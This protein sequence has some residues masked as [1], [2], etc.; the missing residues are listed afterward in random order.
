MIRLKNIFSIIVLIILIA[1]CSEYLDPNP[2][3]GTYD[4]EYVWSTPSFAE[5][6][7]I[8]AFNNIHP[9]SWRVQNNELMA[10][11]TDDAVSSSISST[12][13]NFAQGLQ[14]PYFNLSHIDTWGGDY[15]SIFNINKFLENIGSVK[16]DPDSAI[17]QQFIRKFKGDAY[18]LRG[19]F[20]WKLLKRFG[21]LSDGEMM[22]I[23]VIK[24]SLDIDESYDI[25]RSTYMETILAINEDLDSALQYVPEAYTGD[26]LVT[27]VQY[28]GAP[29]KAIVLSLKGIIAAY[30]A[31]PAYNPDNDLVRW[32]SAA[33]K[34]SQALLYIDG[35]LN[36]DALPPRNFHEPENPDVIWRAPYDASNYS[37][38]I[39]NYPP[40]LRGDGRT[41]PSQNLV[42][43]FPDSLGYPITDESTVYNSES[44]YEN[45][46][47]R[48]YEAIVYNNSV[49]GGESLTIETFNGGADSRQVNKESGTRTGYYLKKLLSEN[50]T[51]FPERIGIE[52]TF[53]ITIS[54]TDLYLLFIEAMNEL[55][56][57]YDTRYGISSR[58]CL[59]KIRRRAGLDNDQYLLGTA[60]KGK[61]AMRE[62][63]RNERRIELCFEDHRYWDLRRWGELDKINTD[64]YGMI[65]E[66]SNDSTFT[67][68]R[69][70]VEK[71]EYQS[72]Y[73]PLPFEEVLK[74]NQV[75]QNEGW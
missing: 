26:D 11:L 51:L 20:H 69:K 46:D 38:E 55:A 59:V 5:G 64:V 72:I 58:N 6:V 8:Q 41:N 36:T 22:G 18:F 39:N 19:F 23:P 62:L 47:Q 61:E 60:A 37:N 35:E 57:P 63:I 28:Y 74:M 52:P 49:F 73:N 42:D 50:V 2:Y 15:S 24:K 33:S 40:S 3:D 65:I 30:A 54:K 43:A 45:R 7:L 67:Y 21:G 25:P 4:E 16:Y 31:S 10:I 48:F 44:P 70:M 9:S 17:N 32:D 75:S 68:T 12:S 27:G 71:R 66:R 53:Y 29:T 56:G 13:G 14:S 34:L 1:G